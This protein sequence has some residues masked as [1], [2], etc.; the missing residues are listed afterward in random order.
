MIY[1][2]IVSVTFRDLTAREIIDLSVKAGLEGIEWG[3][4]VH[5]PHGDVACAREVYKMTTESGLKVAAYGSYYRLGIEKEGMNTFDKV[6]ET[7]VELRAPVIRVW[8]GN[9]G[10]ADADE[11]W[12]NKCVEESVRIAEMAQKEGIKVAYEYHLKTLTDTSKTAVK[13]LKDVNHV[14]M[15]SYWQPLR[16]MNEEEKVQSLKDI[17]PWLENLHVQYGTSEGRQPLASGREWI[18]YLGIVKELKEDRFAMVEFVKDNKPEQ[19]LE[20]ARALKEFIALA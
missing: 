6:L 5:V 3:G 15:R 9:I 4:D 16:T 18:K 14:N 11:S 10:S 8:A 7:A 12:W 1:P 17:L 20:D 13:L 2:G 19:L